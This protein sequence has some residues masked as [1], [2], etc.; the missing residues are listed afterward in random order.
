M[1][2]LQGM[3]VFFPLMNLIYWLDRVSLIIKFSSSFLIKIPRVFLLPPLFWV[4]FLPVSGPLLGNS[5]WGRTVN[6]AQVL[7]SRWPSCHL[8]SVGEWQGSYLGPE[9]LLGDPTSVLFRVGYLGSTREE[10]L[11][12][13]HSLSSHLLTVFI[14]RISYVSPACLYIKAVS[15]FS[16]VCYFCLGDGRRVGQ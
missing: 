5:C 12:S 16:R 7:G 4:S 11:D 6:H 3:L 2:F 14:R 9:G 1:I 10:I 8:S 15:T 13:L